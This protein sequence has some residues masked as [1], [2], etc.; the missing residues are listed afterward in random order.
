MGWL[1]AIALTHDCAL[2]PGASILRKREPQVPIARRVVAPAFAHLHEQEQ[3]HRPLEQLRQLLARLR[4]HLL[5]HAAALA[6]HDALLAVALDEDGLLD[7]DA[8][9]L[10]LPRRG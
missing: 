5:D 6:Q 2:P 9:L 4:R 3:V 10:L 7:A 8:V 1:G